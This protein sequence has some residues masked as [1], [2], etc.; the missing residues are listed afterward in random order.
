MTW[1]MEEL[2]G[3]GDDAVANPEKF[4]YEKHLQKNIAIS[5]PDLPELVTSR[6]GRR[7]HHMSRRESACS[8]L[9]RHIYAPKEEEDTQPPDPP[10]QADAAAGGITPA[11]PAG[12][13][14][15][16]DPQEPRPGEPTRQY[17][18]RSQAKRKS[19]E[20]IAAAKEDLVSISM[21]QALTVVPDM[22]TT[23]QGVKLR[24]AFG[25]GM[26]RKWHPRVATGQPGGS[27]RAAGRVGRNAA[28]LTGRDRPRGDAPH[29]A[30]RRKL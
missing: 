5:V 24:E 25:D 16:L 11:D 17:W 20:S 21:N 9:G 28:A 7:G 12:G 30:G 29:H 13:K 3:E 18:Q 4:A 1:D 2:M 15:D 6:A 27:A 22:I 19:E 23:I 14:T 8:A 10:S 26:V